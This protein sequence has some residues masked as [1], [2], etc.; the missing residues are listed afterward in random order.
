MG[1]EG[2]EEGRSEEGGTT[3]ERKVPKLKVKLSSVGDTPKVRPASVGGAGSSEEVKRLSRASKTSDDT[4]D[5]W[6]VG[7]QLPW[8]PACISLQ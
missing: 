1:G 5:R 3:E 2:W 4:D 7:Y 8:L 6:E